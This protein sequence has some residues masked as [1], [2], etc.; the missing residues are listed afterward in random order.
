MKL[1]TDP[2]SRPHPL[3]LGGAE[4]NAQGFRGLSFTEAGEEPALEIA[5]ETLVALAQPVEGAVE[6]E[7]PL[8]LFFDGDAGVEASAL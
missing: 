2:G 4:R 3:A 7:K 1:R 5:R 8:R 6:I